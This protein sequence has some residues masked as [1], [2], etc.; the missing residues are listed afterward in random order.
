MT[1]YSPFYLGVEARIPAGCRTRPPLSRGQKGRP[2]PAL[3]YCIY[4]LLSACFYSPSPA[5]HEVWRWEIRSW[6]GTSSSSL[7][8]Q[9]KRKD[10][11]QVPAPKINN[12][13]SIGALVHHR[14]QVSPMSYNEKSLFFAE[15]S[16]L[17]HTLEIFL[18]VYCSF[19]IFCLWWV[20]LWLSFP[21]LH[22]EKN[23]VSV[24]LNSVS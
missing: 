2:I 10:V 15:D 4:L 11:G 14:Y 24:I 8:P 7:L 20:L 17:L 13:G 1:S 22:P 21:Q 19:P 3:V 6:L 18:N 9:H 5:S 16:V 12:P 23:P